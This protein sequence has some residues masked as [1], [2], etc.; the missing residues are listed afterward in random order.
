[1]IQPSYGVT[2]DTHLDLYVNRLIGIDKWGIPGSLGE[3][4]N[5][6]FD[7]NY[8]YVTLDGRTMYF[9]SKGHNSIGGYDIFKVV[10][11]ENGVFGEHK[12]LGYPINT[13]DDNRYFVLAADAQNGYYS[14]GGETSIGE[15]D[16]FKIITGKI[17]KPVLALLLG[18]VYLDDK[19]TGSTMNLYNKEDG[20]LQGTFVSNMETGKYVMALLPG[21]YEIEVEL[22]S[23]ELVKDSLD[24]G[25]IK[26]YIV[27]HKDFRIYSDSNLIAKNEPSLQAI[28]NKEM[29]RGGKTIDTLFTDNISSDINL[30]QMQT[31]NTFALKGI[32]YDFDKSTLRDESKKELNNLIAIL[33]E[34]PKLEIEISSHTDAARNVEMATKVLRRYG[35]E[36]S[37]E[38][39]NLMSK[40]YNILLSKRRADAVVAYLSKNGISSNRLIA[41][42]YGEEEP[43]ATNETE[44]GRQINRRTEF[45]VLELK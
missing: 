43:I 31:G 7:E 24:L 35:K 20:E 44:E 10:A 33:K 45:K 29:T 11:D 27:L 37:V 19:V 21:N 16:I 39:H 8:A 25:T 28:F 12:N 40:K 42:G 15:Q 3:N 13:I 23:G 14:G 41:T 9:S 5:T 38:A 6:T 1:M 18:K 30:N 26:E 22:E 2:D 34:N 36:Y 17:D 32:E 4:I